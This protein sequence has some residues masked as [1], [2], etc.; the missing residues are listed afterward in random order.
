MATFPR[1]LIQSMVHCPIKT[2]GF[3]RV[4]IIYTHPC[5]S[6]RRYYPQLQTDV[7]LFP[8]LEKPGKIGDSNF[9]AGVI[10]G[11]LRREKGE[12]FPSAGFCRVSGM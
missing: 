7:N 1:V 11:S 8:Y 5:F 10:R 4:I 2:M 3:R 12:L 9:G 6:Y